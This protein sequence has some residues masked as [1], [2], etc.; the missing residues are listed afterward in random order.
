M[1]PDSRD[2]RDRDRD[3]DR[4]R[5]RER[6]RGYTPSGWDPPIQNAWEGHRNLD[7]DSMGRKVPFDLRGSL[8]GPSQLLRGNIFDDDAFKL[9]QTLDSDR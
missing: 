6:E 5:E 8:S 9:D 4:E 1:R 2:G 7:L 3:R